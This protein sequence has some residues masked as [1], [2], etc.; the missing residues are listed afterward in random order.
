[1]GFQAVS[2]PRRPVADLVFKLG[3]P[4]EM[5]VFR[6]NFEIPALV[7][8][9]LCALLLC[10]FLTACDS[11]SEFLGGGDKPGQSREA[12]ADGEGD[13]EGKVNISP[14]KA[15]PGLGLRPPA[16]GETGRERDSKGFPVMKPAL[17]MKTN[18]LFSEK[19]GDSDDRFER[20]E[21]A[22]QEM[23]NDYDAMLPS[24]LRLVAIE[25]DINQ[26][27][28][29]LDTLLKSDPQALPPPAAAMP[30]EAVQQE[31][32]AQNNQTAQGASAPPQNLAPQDKEFPEPDP[33]P[34]GAPPQTLPPI[35]PKPAPV[36]E[37][38][39]PPAPAPALVPANS[40]AGGV[41]VKAPRFG[42]HADYTRIV[43]DVGSATPFTAEL[44]EAE[45]ILL[46]ELPDGRWDGPPSGASSHPLIASWKMNPGAGGKG[47]LISFQLSKSARIKDKMALQNPHRVVVDLAHE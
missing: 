44:D 35:A 12:S 45:K 21:N 25:K 34:A 16:E 13:A 5:A 31:D 1:M 4:Q 37:A 47:V 10:G 38:V 42:S 15:P 14:M 46:V 39:V 7:G 30:V 2:H 28:V 23:R 3:K 41:F 40:A 26:L 9:V 27:V 32:I 22:V 6:G 36:S 8:R 19:I 18:M 24:I 29:Q 11:S 17:G 20:L 43:F 33:A